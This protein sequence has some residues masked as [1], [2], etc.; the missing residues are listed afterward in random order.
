MT[1]MV[2]AND[3]ALFLLEVA[4][5]CAEREP[6]FDD[7]GVV[8]TQGRDAQFRI[9][10]LQYEPPQHVPNRALVT[11]CN[12]LEVL[13]PTTTEWLIVGREFAP[14]TDAASYGIE[15]EEW[16]RLRAEFAA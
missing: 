11:T 4:A 14:H 8:A 13:D 1:R 6:T 9:R 7:E 2:N 16:E 15:D 5:L 10:P 12:L 3:Y